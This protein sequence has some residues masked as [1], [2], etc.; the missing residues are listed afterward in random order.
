MSKFIVGLDLGQAQDYTALCVVE[1]VTYNVPLEEQP[2]GYM[3]YLMPA[4]KTPLPHYHCRHLERFSLGTRY[5]AIV[6]SVA[7]M[8]E[9]PELED[10]ALVVD[11]TGVGRAVLDM[12]VEA[13]LNP[14][15]ITITGGDSVVRDGSYYRVPKRDLV[16]AVQVPLQDKRLKFAEGLPLASTLI[17]EM[18]NFRVKI[19]DS[20]HDTYGA[21]REGTHDDLILAVMMA[22]W[23]AQENEKGWTPEVQAQLINSFRWQG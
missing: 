19:T 6:D 17:D 16:G 11:G 2:K 4:P 21:W 10:A 13:G 8:L 9:T 3:R 5:P 18:L 12:F 14:I 7:K 1:R 20:A 23:W 22:T 15:A